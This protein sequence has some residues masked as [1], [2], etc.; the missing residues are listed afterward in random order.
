MIN[1]SHDKVQSVLG[2]WFLGRDSHW[3]VEQGA[4]FSQTVHSKAGIIN[5]DLVPII[6]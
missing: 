5:L 1:H 4:D 2:R 3:G 6:T